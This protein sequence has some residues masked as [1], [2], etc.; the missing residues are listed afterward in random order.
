MADFG[1]SEI[2]SCDLR[3]SK[4]VPGSVEL[5]NQQCLVFSMRQFLQ[6]MFF[7]PNG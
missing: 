3:V 6:F 4:V 7:S 5:E 1:L 2:S